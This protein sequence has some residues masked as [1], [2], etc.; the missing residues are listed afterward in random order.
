VASRNVERIRVAIREG[1]VEKAVRSLALRAY[2]ALLAASPVDTGFFRAGWTASV[3][4]P[5]RAGP[6]LPA[7][8]SDRDTTVAQASGLLATRQGQAAA[9]AGGY[10]VGQGPAF[11][12]NNVRY[13][14]YLN[15]GSSAQA[16][17]RFV[18]LA[19]LEAVAAT[20]RDLR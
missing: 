16:P 3:G 19:I 7:T 8:P 6:E 17:A 9:V 15:E 4:A 14:V 11:I 12:V 10:K 1:L 13:G 20:K 2:Q 18:E 5:D